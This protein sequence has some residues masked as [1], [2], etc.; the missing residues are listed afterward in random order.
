M[1]A[2]LHVHPFGANLEY[3]CSYV[4]TLDSQVCSHAPPRTPKDA[5][6]EQNATICVLVRCRRGSWSA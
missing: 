5:H 4:H 2:F 6:A 3:L 1:S